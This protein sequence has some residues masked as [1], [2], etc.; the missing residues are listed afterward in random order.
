MPIVKLIKYMK[1]YKY[2]HFLPPCLEFC[3]NSKCILIDIPY[4]SVS[5][6]N[7]FFFLRF[8]KIS[9]LSWYAT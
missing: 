1:W 9:H 5:V 7:V 8:S 2:L 6:V 3:D 4:S